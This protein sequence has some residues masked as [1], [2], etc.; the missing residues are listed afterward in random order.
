MLRIIFFL[1]FCCSFVQAEAKDT[2]LSTHFEPVSWLKEFLA[3]HE[4]VYKT[5]S[6]ER[7]KI[8]FHPGYADVYLEPRFTNILA[9]RREH[10]SVVVNDVA[11]KFLMARIL[12]WEYPKPNVLIMLGSWDY[13]VNLEFL[14]DGGHKSKVNKGGNRDIIFAI[15][16]TQDGYQA[17]CTSELYKPFEV[18][19]DEAKYLWKNS[20]NLCME[21]DFGKAK[22]KEWRMKVLGFPQQKSSVHKEILDSEKLSPFDEKESTRFIF[23]R[24]KSKAYALKHSHDYNSS[25]PKFG[26]DCTNFASQILYHGG[27]PMI[28]GLDNDAEGFPNMENWYIRKLPNG[29]FAYNQ[30]WS[31]ASTF[32]RNIQHHKLGSWV[33]FA[34]DLGIGD[35]IFLHTLAVNRITHV[36][37]VCGCS[38]QESGYGVYPLPNVCA[39]SRDRKDE[40]INELP[41]KLPDFFRFFR[42]APNGVTGS[43]CAELLAPPPPSNPPVPPA[44][45]GPICA[46]PNPKPPLYAD[47]RVYGND[48][49][50]AH[51][52]LKDASPDGGPRLSFN[53]KAYQMLY[54]SDPKWLKWLNNSK[55]HSISTAVI[56]EM[57]RRG[58]RVKSLPVPEHGNNGT[59][60]SAVAESN[61]AFDRARAAYSGP[62][63]L[64]GFVPWLDYH[65]THPACCNP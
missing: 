36:Y 22:R 39:H 30:G 17:I 26:S 42:M 46:P 11:H 64:L 50:A 25:Y 37:F 18:D 1:F 49:S 41:I 7:I 59:E 44:P 51:N 4:E 16:K 20:T 14:R 13:T 43:T 32:A 9:M 12:D 34:G 52:L 57:G 48:K 29:K 19:M 45:P 58:I 62:Q 2:P 55:N 33:Q 31:V 5:G 24:N 21:D 3:A 56:N 28:G 38:L 65:P 53:Y 63:C 40:A 47:F 54:R 8:L 35:L 6:F 23:E 61:A 10:E 27:R 60:V 15:E